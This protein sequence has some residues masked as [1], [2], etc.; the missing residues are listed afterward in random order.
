MNEDERKIEPPTR[1]EINEAIKSLRN[2][3]APGINN[4][5]GELFKA[6]SQEVQQQMGNILS[7]IWDTEQIPKEWKMG[8]ICSIYKKGDKTQCPNYRAITVLN[9]AYKILSS[10]ILQR[11]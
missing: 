6:G 2:N 7:R 4:L 11:M 1:L 10:I 3:K 9:V 8:I 5:T